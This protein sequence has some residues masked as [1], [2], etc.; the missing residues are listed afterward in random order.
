MTATA[1]LDP[2]KI[3][4][5]LQPNGHFARFVRSFEA[6]PQ[7]QEMLKVIIDAYNED[8]IALIEAG[9]G[10]GKSLA[11]L[12]PAILWAVKHKQRT[13]ISTHTITL[14]EQLLKKDIP[15]VCQ[16]LDAKIK[17]VLNG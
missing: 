15:L 10:T 12:I 3:A 16:A 11:Y 6:R 4:E 7:Q 5:L 13:L 8:K 17:E 9:T 2:A 1:L 14:Q